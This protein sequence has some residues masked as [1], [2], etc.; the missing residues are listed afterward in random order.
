MTSIGKL[1]FSSF[2]CRSPQFH[3]SL[4]ASLSPLL[5][6]ALLSYSSPNPSRSLHNHHILNYRSALNCLLLPGISGYVSFLPTVL[7]HSLLALIHFVSTTLINEFFFKPIRSH[8]I[9]PL[10]TPLFR[11]FIVII[12]PVYF[13]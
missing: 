12:T 2:P 10:V 7:S 6:F 8:F 11:G 1:S 4:L 9:F 13:S 3:P 5:S